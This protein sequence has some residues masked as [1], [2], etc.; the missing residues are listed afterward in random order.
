[1]QISPTVQQLRHRTSNLRENVALAVMW[2]IDVHHLTKVDVNII[3]H[4]V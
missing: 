4:V 3:P 1:M 2:I